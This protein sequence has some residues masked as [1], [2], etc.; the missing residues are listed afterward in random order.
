MNRDLDS[1]KERC[2]HINVITYVDPAGGSD[3]HY[4]CQDV[5]LESKEKTL[6]E[7]D[8]EDWWDKNFKKTLP[9]WKCDA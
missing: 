2:P 6:V 7:P 4:E 9:D 5:K 3:S 1:L 8:K